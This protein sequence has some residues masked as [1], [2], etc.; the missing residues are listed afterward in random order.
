MTHEKQTALLRKLQEVDFV[1]VELTLYLDTHPDDHDAINQYNQCSL[2][3]E[4]IR[5]EYEE[6][7]GPLMHFGHSYNRYPGGWSEGPWPWEI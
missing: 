7:Y 5:S 2:E 1:L 6:K 4:G 3:R